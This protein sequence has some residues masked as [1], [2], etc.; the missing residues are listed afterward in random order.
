MPFRIIATDIYCVPQEVRLPY[1]G[2]LSNNPLFIIKK[3]RDKIL[4]QFIIRS[5]KQ[6]EYYLFQSNKYLAEMLLQMQA[7]NDAYVIKTGLRSGNYLTLF[8]SLYG[9][10]AQNNPSILNKL[11]CDFYYIIE[12]QIMKYN[13]IIANMQYGE[14]KK[15]LIQIVEQLKQNKEGFDNLLTTMNN[16]IIIYE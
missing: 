6:L 12:F 10:L 14:Q 1:P 16:K 3:I 2:M 8:V 5:D 13:E 7:K 9:Q 11:A 15:Q 4:E